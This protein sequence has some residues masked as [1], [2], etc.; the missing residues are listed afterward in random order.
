MIRAK[1]PLNNEN[2]FLKKR[3]SVEK[4]CQVQCFTIKEKQSRH[5]PTGSDH[6]EAAP[7]AEKSFFINRL[8][9]ILDPPVK[10]EDDDVW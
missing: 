2:L 10:P 6:P 5:G 1:I 9:P 3:C 4:K 7:A 8:E